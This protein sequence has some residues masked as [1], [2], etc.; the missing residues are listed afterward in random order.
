MRVRAPAKINLHLRVGP[1]RDDGFHPLLSWMCTVGLFDTLE[2]SFPTQVDP[3]GGGADD[4]CANALLTLASDDPALPTDAGVNLV[5]RAATAL[6]DTLSASREGPRTGKRVS[7]FLNKRIPTGAGLGGGSSDA[8]ATLVALN[9]LWDAKRSNAQLAEIGATIGS[10]VPLFLHGPSSVC[11]GRG[12]V[13]RPIERPAPRWALLVMPKIGISTASVYRMFDAMRRSD[14][15][16]RGRFDSAHHEKS[17]VVN[18]PEWG[19]WVR[20]DACSLLPRL[21]NDLES[22]AFA[23][24][25]TVGELRTSLEENLKRPVRMSG[26]GSTL[27]TLFDERD[28]AEHAARRVTTTDARTEVVEVAPLVPSPGTPGEG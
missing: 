5:T 3:P 14:S 27:F 28:E 25:P 15:A 20:L 11:S 18:E 6:A 7:A 12:E 24:E 22:A 9:R 1:A 10:D 4:T 13:V 16:H 2:F 19:T 8:A 23:V 26:S 17:V 21:V